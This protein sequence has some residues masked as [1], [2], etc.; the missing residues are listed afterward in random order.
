M[1]KRRT[2]EEV[3]KAANV[4][5]TREYERATTTRLED[6]YGSYSVFK[7]RA[8]RWCREKMEKMSGWGY[9][10]TSHNC[11]FFTVM[12]EYEN[13]ETGEIMLNKETAHGSYTFSEAHDW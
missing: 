7:A 6:V 4:A 5:A 13:P 10:I 9:K 11:N 8:D 2:H 12:W 3:I 1:A